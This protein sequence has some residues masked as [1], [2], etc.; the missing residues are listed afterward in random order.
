MR[1]LII[2]AICGLIGYW[3][4]TQNQLDNRY[5]DSLSKNGE[6]HTI[7]ERVSFA[8]Q[9]EYDLEISKDEVI[10]N[11][12]ENGE[13]TIGEYQSYYD[14]KTQ[15]EQK[16]TNQSIE[17][18]GNLYDPE[19][20]IFTGMIKMANSVNNLKKNQIKELDNKIDKIVDNID[21]DGKNLSIIKLSTISW[22]PVGDKL[23]D[24]EMTDFYKNKIETV[25]RQ[26]N[27]I[28]SVTPN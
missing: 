6:D 22:H 14:E 7:F 26:V 25:I 27:Q 13:I 3:S 12:L 18:L 15:R 4:Y 5:Y 19:K 11:K 8:L 20:G 28:E 2:L 9:R 10:L 21:I 1:Y 24:S 17:D 23:I 16:E